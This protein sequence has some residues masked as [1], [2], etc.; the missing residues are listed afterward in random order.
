MKMWV[1]DL[2]APLLLLNT[3]IYYIQSVVGVQLDSLSCPGHLEHLLLCV[4]KIV[5][6]H[7][8]LLTI[9][10]MHTETPF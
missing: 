1:L 7:V 4:E 8:V 5:C 10:Y 9:D 6:V 3:K 2:I